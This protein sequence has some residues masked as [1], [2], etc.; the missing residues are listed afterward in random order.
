[1]PHH[2]SCLH[3]QIDSVYWNAAASNQLAATHNQFPPRRIEGTL[4]IYI[5][6]GL[7]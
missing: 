5:E 7:G 1:M 2:L 4:A 3:K 6:L